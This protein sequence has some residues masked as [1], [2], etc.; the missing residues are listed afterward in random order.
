MDLFT[1]PRV[2]VSG[3]GTTINQPCYYFHALLVRPPNNRL[4]LT[5]AA[6]SLLV[7]R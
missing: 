1:I 4:E 3:R 5:A 2:A 6:G 7:P